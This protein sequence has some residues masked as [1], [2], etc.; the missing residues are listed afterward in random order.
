MKTITQQAAPTAKP[1][2]VNGPPEHVEASELVSMLT[3]LPR[4]NQIVPYPR[5][6]PGSAQPISH[7]GIVAAYIQDKIHA[8]AAAHRYALEILADPKKA[9]EEKRTKLSE[10]EI[11]TLGY[12]G[13]FKNACAI[14]LLFRVCKLAKR[15]PG[16]PSGEVG[17][18][19]YE[20]KEPLEPA[21]P[22]ARWMRE[23]CT[24][25]E[26]GVL[27]ATFLRVQREIGPIVAML[28][29]AEADLWLEKLI[30]G[31]VA[32][33]PFDSLASGALIDLVM[34]SVFHLRTYRKGKSSSGEPPENGSTESG[35]SSDQASEPG[36]S[37]VVELDEPPA[38]DALPVEAVN[39]NDE[40]RAT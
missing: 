32:L 29:D 23:H 37:V 20:L 31:G 12:A 21:F 24:D 11:Q 4:P 7:L 8:Q 30:A 35:L 13:V 28:S 9:L 27:T 39:P 33:D 34:R 25:D 2:P 22:G 36:E 26:I 16:I 40:G 5:K 19:D 18:N 3:T 15:K 17:P 10:D 14:E 6:L 1:A 38:I